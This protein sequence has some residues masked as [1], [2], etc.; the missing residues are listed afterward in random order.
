MKLAGLV[1]AVLL[2]AAIPAAQPGRPKI[3]RGSLAAIEA[4]FDAS[5]TRLGQND[6]FDLL[7]N[8]RGVYL[9]DYGVVFTTE[10]NLIVTPTITP[11][12][13]AISKAETAK[14]RERKL[15]RLTLLKQAMRDMLFQSAA[16]LAALSAGEQVVLGV[17]LFYFPWEDRGGLPSQILMRARKSALLKG[18]GE[19]LETAV[20]VEEF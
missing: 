14:V 17:T 18:A 10:L 3:T 15:Q 5:I 11:F 6:P 9:E 2:A 7:G 4:S 19:A 16:G 20:K 1:A 8:T 13:P 12:R